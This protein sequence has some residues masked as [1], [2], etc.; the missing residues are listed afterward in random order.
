MQRRYPAASAMPSASPQDAPGPAPCPPPSRRRRAR[1]RAP[2]PCRHPSTPSCAGP[3]LLALRL[4]LGLDALAL[5]FAEEAERG[6]RAGRVHQ[7]RIVD[8]AGILDADLA[9]VDDAIE[10]ADPVEELRELV[11]GA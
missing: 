7:H 9:D 11:I 3:H 6:R 1:A 8:D 2:A 4:L 10:L 5:R